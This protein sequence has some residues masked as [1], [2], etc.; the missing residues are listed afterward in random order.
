MWQ[1]FVF[2]SLLDCDIQF[3]SIPEVRIELGL[4]AVY[5]V[6]EKK[7]WLQCRRSW[8][9]G[10]SRGDLPNHQHLQF[11]YFN[12]I[13]RGKGI[14]IK[15]IWFQN[16]L[17]LCLNIKVHTVTHCSL[18]ATSIKVHTS[19]VVCVACYLLLGDIAKAVALTGPFGVRQINPTV[20]FETSQNNQISK[21]V[22]NSFE[23]RQNTLSDFTLLFHSEA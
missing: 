18:L 16:C 8:S 21:Q 9:I 15:Q 2:A 20:G 12:L 10:A 4:R 22:R 6:R 1:K 17:F 19:I 5:F 3:N 14:R 7:G 23:K 13:Q 11:M